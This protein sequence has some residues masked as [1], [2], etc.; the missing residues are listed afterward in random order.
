[1]ASIM[2]IIWPRLRLRLIKMDRKMIL[3]VLALEE[4]DVA[5]DEK[6]LCS[7]KTIDGLALVGR[8]EDLVG[9]LVVLVMDF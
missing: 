1:M 9:F 4:F 5:T 7:Y 3:M 2:S 8:L 6:P